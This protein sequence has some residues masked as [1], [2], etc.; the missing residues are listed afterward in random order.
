MKVQVDAKLG[1]PST[2]LSLTSFRL[3]LMLLS[4]LYTDFL[5]YYLQST[6]AEVKLKGNFW[7]EDF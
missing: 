1:F 7:N 6:I 2:P 3:S 5:Y 4:I